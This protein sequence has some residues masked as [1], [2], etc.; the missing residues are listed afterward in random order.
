[1]VLVQHSGFLSLIAKQVF[2]SMGSGSI[3]VICYMSIS[4]Q[5]TRSS[6]AGCNAVEDIDL[7]AH[8]RH[9]H[10]KGYGFIFI[11]V[12]RIVASNGESSSTNPRQ[13]L[14]PDEQVRRDMKKKYDIS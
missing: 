13:L 14:P 6:A 1:M 8:G 2:Q 10:L 12:F 4:R 5:G 3:N 11:E 9:V 7:P